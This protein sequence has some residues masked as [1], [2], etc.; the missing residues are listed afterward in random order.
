MATEG[1]PATVLRRVEDGSLQ[2]DGEVIVLVDS[3]RLLRFQAPSKRW[4]DPTEVLLER[5]LVAVLA[6]PRWS[7]VIRFSLIVRCDITQKL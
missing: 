4:L 3:T 1:S 7:S 6:M 5:S 2:S